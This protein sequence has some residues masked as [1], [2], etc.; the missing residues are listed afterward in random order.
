MP[1][2]RLEKIAA[3]EAEQSKLETQRKTLLEA[4]RAQERKDRTRR[5]CQRGGLLEKMLPDTIP[6]SDEQFQS[7]LEKTVAND[8]GRRTL[9]K[10][11]AQNAANPA[12]QGGGSAAQNSTTTE[13]QG[14]GTAAQGTTL[15]TAKP[16][17]N[18]QDSGKDEDMGEGES[19]RV[20]G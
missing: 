12:P 7:F 17:Q 20:S 9:E 5:L 8:F 6:L 13:P 14:M 4:H 19:A 2:T 10:F 1:K 15:P 11:T 16:P 18:T 3:I